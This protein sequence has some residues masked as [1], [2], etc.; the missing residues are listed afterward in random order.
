MP[1]QSFVW[2]R[3]SSNSSLCAM[4][5]PK[6]KRLSARNALPEARNPMNMTRTPRQ[7]QA[8]QE[9]VVVVA[10]TVVVAQANQGKTSAQMSHF[11]GMDV[12]LE[13][14]ELLDSKPWGLSLRERFELCIVKFAKWAG[15]LYDY[16]GYD[17]QRLDFYIKIQTKRLS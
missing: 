2:R 11:P 15:W 14:Q 16:D 13:R 1:N 5:K 4:P 9:P 10:Q 7:V 12:P 3:L 17:Q 8:T 6:H